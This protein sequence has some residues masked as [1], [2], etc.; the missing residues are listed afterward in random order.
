MLLPE[1][2]EKGIASK[3]ANILIEIARSEGKTDRIIAII[4]PNNIPSGKILIKK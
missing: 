1:N 3:V 4:D 2:W